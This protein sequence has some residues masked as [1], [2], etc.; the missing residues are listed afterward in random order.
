MK[1]LHVCE[2][3]EGGVATAVANYVDATPEFEHILLCSTRS[4]KLDCGI[5]KRFSTIY[6][7]TDSKLG[8]IKDVKRSVDKEKPDVIHCHSS[9]GGLFGRAAKAIYRF[10]APVVYSPHCFAFERKD[11]GMVKQGAFTIAEKVL[12]V[13]TAATVAC[14]E[15]EKWLANRLS[16]RQKVVFVPNVAGIKP[17]KGVKKEGGR[18]VVATIGRLV[19]QKDPSFFA[20]IAKRFDD[21]MKFEFVWIGDGDREY[22]KEL[23]AAGVR[24]TGWLDQAGMARELSRADVY[25]HTARWEGFPIAILDAVALGKSVLA[26]KSEYLM[27]MPKRWTF[28][29]PATSDL[30]T[31]YGD[32]GAGGKMQN[33]VGDW[34]R[35]LGVNTV[36]NVAKRLREVYGEV[37]G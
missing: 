9:F 32:R 36:E 34:R 30:T 2:S 28:E 33:C 12:S 31:F 27:G 17:I 10:P 7:F 15:R 35:A 11:I 22:K 29:H 5:N 24:V 14:S 4:G 21:F 37:V 13:W 8:C 1:I 3:F 6:R 18:M 19:P 25:V 26:R 16:R 20:E 23:Q